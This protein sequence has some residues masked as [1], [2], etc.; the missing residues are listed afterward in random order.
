MK[1]II[2]AIIAIATAATLTGCVG[3][4]GRSIYNAAATP[5]ADVCTKTLGK[6]IADAEKAIN[7]GKADSVKKKLSG[8]QIRAYSKGSLKAELTV[9]TDGIVIE[10]ACDQIPSK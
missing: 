8:D 4:L 3:S 10:A 2:L 6:N 1:R 9:G 7:M 5:D